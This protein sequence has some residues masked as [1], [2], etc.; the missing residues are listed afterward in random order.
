MIEHS[1]DHEVAGHPCFVPG[2]GIL[3]VAE[4]LK[5]KF[6]MA[7]RVFIHGSVP[8]LIGGH[9]VELD[10]VRRATKEEIEFHFAQMRSR[11]VA[12]D[13][14]DCWCRSLKVERR[15]EAP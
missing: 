10:H 3:W 1:Y 2:H 4:V 13:A 14:D 11:G 8:G 9:L 12:C 5:C 7:A 6:G 15:E